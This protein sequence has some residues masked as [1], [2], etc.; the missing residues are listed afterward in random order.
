MTRQ[1]SFK[2]LVRTRMERTG[3]S[4]TAARTILLA[5][6]EPDSATTT[7]PL[8][9]SDDTIRERTGRGWEEWFDLL[10][11]QGMADRTHREIARWVAE[12]LGVVP[13][14][15]GPQAV[16]ISY[17]R[18]R[19]GRAVGQHPDGFTITATRT[20]AAPAERVFDAFVDGAARGSLAP[21]RRAARA[22]RNPPEVGPVR[23]GGRDEPGQRHVRRQ[24]RRDVHRVG[25]AR[26]AARR[27]AGREDEN[28]VAGAPQR[29]EG[30]ARER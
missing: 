29:A 9:T 7:A 23:L 27:G 4:Y 20:V 21:R 15:W 17:E 25:R 18:A 13:L 30:A 16:T 3:E 2:R 22:H 26:S 28:L 24:E 12:L 5:A 1:R 11:E 10:D 14:A 6:R 19:G 8:A